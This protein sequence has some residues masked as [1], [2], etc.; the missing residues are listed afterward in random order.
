MKRPAVHALAGAG[1]VTLALV[2]AGC[3]GGSVPTGG[4]SSEPQ[5][6]E[7]LTVGVQQA[8]ANLDPG[9]LDKAFTDFTMLA[10]DPLFYMSP[11]GEV[12][13]RLAESWEYVGD[14]NTELVVQI[15]EGVEFS[16]GDALNADAVKGSLEYA[17]DS[18]GSHSFF[19][20]DMTFEATEEFELTITSAVSNPTIPNVLTQVYPIG[21]IISPTGLKDP[22]ALTLEGETHGAGQY[23]YDADATVIG[24]HFTYTANPNYWNEDI[25]Y[26]DEVT[27][28]IVDNHQAALNAA[29]TGQIDVF[30]GDLTVAQQ[31]ASA[32][33]QVIA[34]PAIL[35]GLYLTDRAGEVTPALAE[36]KVRQ[37]INFAIDRESVTKALAGEYGAPTF[38]TSMDGTDGFSDEV[39][40]FY[41]Y[42]PAKAKKLLAEAGYPD[43][44]DLTIVTAVFAGF[45][46]L[47]EAIKAQLAE[48]G[49]NVTT[50][51]KTDIGGYSEAVTGG[52]YSAFVG[53]FSSAPM[54]Q[55]GID[56]WLPGSNF[57][58]PFA[59]ESPELTSLWTAAAAAGEDERAPLD[60]QMQSYL[61]E[62]AWNAPVM[63]A[64]AIYFARDEI[65]GVATSA[66]MPFAS[67]FDWYSRAH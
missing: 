45:E 54:Y 60:A 61:V 49:I 58:N 31:A 55:Q 50:D 44:F 13:P 33:L 40:D 14:A 21:Q 5:H 6:G 36:V 27:Y 10:Y 48:V 9:T 23:V 41:T 35:T 64:P 11:E 7:A 52:D 67:P 62:N 30:K 3:S 24:D 19:L 43:G 34:N 20:K 1:A 57:Y 4:A 2:L 22:S 51:V 8:P 25:Q 15:R 37:A 29:K 32:G 39:A 59:S 42:D 17:R 18:N 63:F 12:Q 28:Q 65:G 16:D 46:P 38:Q 66:G 47:G 53:G 26:W 56:F